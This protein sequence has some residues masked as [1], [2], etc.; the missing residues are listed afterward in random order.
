MH[1]ALRLMIVLVLALCGPSGAMLLAA[2]APETPAVSIIPA[3]VSISDA[4]LQALQLRLNNLKQQ[5]SQISNYSLLEGPQDLAQALIREVDRLSAL[6]LPEQAQ[7]QAQLG[8]LT[9]APLTGADRK[10]PRSPVNAR[11]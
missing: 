6:L 9:P 4:D 10:S 1:Y 2:P 3:S 5:V 8:V 7:L 11:H